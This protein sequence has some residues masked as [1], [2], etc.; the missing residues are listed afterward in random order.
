M[1]GVMSGR[2]DAE[3]TECGSIAGEGEDE[4]QRRMRREALIWQS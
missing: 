1:C 3:I 4:S 2:G